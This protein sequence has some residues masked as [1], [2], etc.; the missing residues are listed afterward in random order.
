MSDVP[1]TISAAVAEADRRPTLVDLARSAAEDGASLV[2]GEIELAKAE[3]RQSAQQAGKGAGMLGGAALLG[4][5]AWLL[6]S[7]AAAFGL[8]AAGL[9]V[10]AGMLVIA[11]VYLLVAAVLVLLGRRE[12]TRS[13]PLE[14]TKAD[15]ATL[16]EQTK[17][18]L[19][20]PQ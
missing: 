11:V 8:V 7:F 16:V 13:K 19:R 9:P 2:R 5:T 3:M 14:R 10:W 20:P 4:L 15:V 18:A 12:L 6:L 17:S 1:Q